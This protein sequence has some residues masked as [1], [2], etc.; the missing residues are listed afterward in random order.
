MPALRR[1]APCRSAFRAAAMLLCV[2]SLA[3]ARLPAQALSSAGTAFWAAALPMGGDGDTVRHYVSATA[4]RHCTVTVRNPRSGWR[5]SF[6]VP[7]GGL[8]T[9]LLPD[10]AVAGDLEEEG[11]HI[12]ATDTVQ[13]WLFC[14]GGQPAACAATHLLPRQALGGEYLVPSFP[15]GYHVG[16]VATADSTT[17]DIVPFG[18]AAADSATAAMLHAGQV[19]RLPAP[20]H[21]AAVAAR[22]CK[23]IALFAGSTAG[24]AAAYQQLLPGSALA[25]AWLP[26]PAAAG[27]GDTVSV[28]AGGDSCHIHCDGQRLATVGRGETYRFRLQR[29]SLVT[30]S[31]PALLYQYPARRSDSAGGSMALFAPNTLRQTS[32]HCTFP[33]Y[34]I[35][36]RA[37]QRDSF[38]VNIVVPSCDTAL[39]LLN[40]APLNGFDTVAGTAHSH[41]R[42]RFGRTV[43]TL[44]TEG[45]GFAAFCHGMG[46]EGD[47]YALSLGGADTAYHERERVRHTVDTATCDTLLTWRDRTYAVPT[48]DSVA[49]CDTLFVLRIAKGAAYA[50]TADTAVCPGP[51][52]WDDTVL[53]A[54]GTH[55][56]HYTAGDG[57]DSAATLILRHLPTYETYDTLA[58]GGVPRTDSLLSVH[59]CDSIVHRIA[60]APSCR[61]RLWAPN[62]FTPGQGDGGHFRIVSHD[63]T[64]MTVR[65]YRR[66]GVLIHSFD[67]LAEHWDGTLSGR[68]CP[69]GT[70]TYIIHYRT[71]CQH[72]P[73]PVAGTVTLVR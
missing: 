10:G 41:L 5:H 64:A 17:V 24:G 58:D 8:T 44:A 29:A 73:K 63:V 33:C 40:N 39:L 1:P 30:T 28:T 72:H 56:R 35:N 22:D 32:R 25:T 27:G 66:D 36:D 2:L 50:D 67:G 9:F 14:A 3:P 26:A 23:P 11:L 20:R 7:A 69:Q 6:P 21:G 55:T 42:K 62:L 43:L 54:A 68:P 16:I 71:P 46:A 37:G 65:L 48:T 53:T 52:L 34:N 12:T 49:E 38:L 15:T 45:S 18:G 60:A 13:L 70:Y 19:Y 4:R 59:G 31:Q 51:F 47:G 61:P 57:C